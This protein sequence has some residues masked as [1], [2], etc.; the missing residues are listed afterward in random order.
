MPSDKYV[1]SLKA[2][3]D[4]KIIAKFTIEKFGRSQSLKY[5]QGLKRML[6][7]LSNNPDLGKRYVPVKNQ[8]L[9]RYRY[10]AHVIFYHPISE[11]IFIVRVLGGRMDF[12]RHLM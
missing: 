10:K 2:K 5:A 3:A 8:M 9:L 11:G 6:Q 12:L 7:D 1:I 4:L